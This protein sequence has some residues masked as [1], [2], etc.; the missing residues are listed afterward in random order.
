MKIILN[1]LFFFLFSCVV[2]FAFA[3]STEEHLQNQLSH[4]HRIT[5]HFKQTITTSRGAVLQQSFGTMAIERPGKFS[6]NTE[7]PLK[8]RVVTDGRKV[9]VYD[10]A[11]EQA[12]VRFLNESVSE[13]PVLLLTQSNTYLKDKFSIQCLAS[14][15]K[16]QKFRLIP[17]NKE[18]S[19]K[20]II[21]V[22]KEN[23]IKEMLLLNQIE[24]K[25]K[26]VFSDVRINPDI[27]PSEFIFNAPS[28]V[29]VIDQTKAL[30]KAE[31]T[32]N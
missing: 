31:K 13:T 23:K 7:K 18:E 30:K 6:W 5:A 10:P 27:K 15:E 14:N 21:L 4:F 19:F 3:Q 24:Q 16:E 32:S 28:D 26:I 8:Q 12:V 25:I 29:D 1:A 11:L 9:W 17:L 22:F 2:S 20:N